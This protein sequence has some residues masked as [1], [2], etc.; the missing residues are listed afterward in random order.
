MTRSEVTSAVAW[1]EI[2]YD[3]GYHNNAPK[4]ERVEGNFH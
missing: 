3:D 2:C 1:W 4:I